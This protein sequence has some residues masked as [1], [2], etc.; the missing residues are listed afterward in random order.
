MAAVGKLAFVVLLSLMV[1]IVP[2]TVQGAM[3][4]QMVINSLTPC[5]TYVTRGGPVP[6]SCCS[7]ISSLYRSATTTTDRQTAC[8]C[9]EQG[10]GMIPGLN[11]DAAST[12]P[13]KC[14][15]NIPYK[16]SPSTDCSK[17]Q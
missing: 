16:I 1:A 9:L 4:C 3:T 6:P 10:V 11:L 8:K 17:V 5:A 12:L 2:H 15:V 13:S 14:G 7:G